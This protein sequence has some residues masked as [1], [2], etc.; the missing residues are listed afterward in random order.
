MD[1]CWGTGRAATCRLT[2]RR[3]K[4]PCGIEMDTSLKRRL[5][6]GLAVIVLACG[7]CAAFAEGVAIT[8]QGWVQSSGTNFSGV[9]QFKFALIGNTNNTTWSNDGT[10][11]DGSEP[12]NAVKVDVIE[13][14]F[15]VVL[16]DTTVSNM[17]ALPA[18]VFAQP[19][20]RLQ[21]WFNDGFY[22][23]SA[24]SPA[25]KLTSAPYAGAAQFASGFLSP[26]PPVSAMAPADAFLITEGSQGVTRTISLSN[27][28][29]SVSGLLPPLPKIVVY[30]NGTYL[31]NGVLVR[32]TN[33]LTCGI[34]EAIDALPR[35]KDKTQPGG[36]TIVLSPGVFYTRANIHTP[37]DG[38]PFT[39][40]LEGTGMTACGITYVGSEPQDVMTVGIP[41][42]HIETLF[43]MHN[44]WMASAVNATTN[45]LRLNGAATDYASVGGVARAEIKFCWFGYWHSMTNHQYGLT[46]ASFSDGAVP[47]DLIGINVDC[48]YDDLIVIEDCSFNY[49][50]GIAVAADHAS[51]RD[52]MFE[53]CGRTQYLNS[54]R[55]PASSIFSV[56]AA[57]TLKEP[58]PP[59]WNGNKSWV[60]EKNKFVNCLVG[61]CVQDGFNRPHLSSLDDFENGPAFTLLATTGS[62]WT[63]VNYRASAAFNTFL[64]T[65]TADFSS[66]NSCPTEPQFV[67]YIDQARGTNS[68]TFSFRGSLASDLFVGNG[69]GITNLPG[70]TTNYTLP[71][72][73]TFYITNGLIMKIQ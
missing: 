9:G 66:W 59:L 45:I 42:S 10:G 4:P 36:G 23:F 41:R 58:T 19:D 14:L 17:V 6:W 52:N 54:N 60:I 16:G 56:G 13:G 34:Q 65:N 5:S 62:K 8:Y 57:I 64:I 32:P 47:H 43:G 38:F 50:N 20:L 2:R 37:T 61:Y 12:V 71:G 51:I 3:A 30:P 68:G 67:T 1:T 26:Q 15:T 49:I 28:A 31:A 73:V 35:S 27:V 18:T 44:M 21:I 55:W 11:K 69:A 25:Q 46:P 72:G 7:V 24:L 33:S 22:G 39:L 53:H 48:N 40:Y 70:L 63:F 29:E